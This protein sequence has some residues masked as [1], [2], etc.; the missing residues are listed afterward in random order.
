LLFFLLLFMLGEPPSP[1]TDKASITSHRR[2][3]Q[4]GYNAEF[5]TY[6]ELIKD[7]TDSYKGY[8]EKEVEISKLTKII[9]DIEKELSK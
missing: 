4:T 9:D 2:A 1:Y 6:N 5:V 3:L 7:A 8:I